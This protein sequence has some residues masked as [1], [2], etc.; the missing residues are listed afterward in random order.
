MPIL[1]EVR[2][3]KELGNKRFYNKY[4]YHACLDCGK[5][6][7]TGYDGGIVNALRCKTCENRRK[8]KINPSLYKKGI[9]SG[10]SPQERNI[11]TP[12]WKAKIS[13]TLTGSPSF[14]KGKERPGLGEKLS[15]LTKGQRRSP[16]SEFKKGQFAKEKHP[17]WKGGV[18]TENRLARGSKEFKEWRKKVFE[19]DDYTCQKCGT[20]SSVGVKVYLHPHHIKDFALFKELRFEVSNGIT[21]CKDCHLKLHGLYKGGDVNVS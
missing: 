8:A 12:E 5:E 18:T 7:W 6:R 17:F 11:C 2:T 20:K 4:I 14:W 3:G 1:G 16:K 13:K 9:G 21:L 19:R 15:K 10:L